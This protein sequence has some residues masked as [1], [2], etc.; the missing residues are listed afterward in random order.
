M[1]STII[2]EQHLDALARLGYF[3]MHANPKYVSGIMRDLRFAHPDL[4]LVENVGPDGIGQIVMLPAVREQI[5]IR[6]TEELEKYQAAAINTSRAIS[7]LT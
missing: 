7:A 2:L 1:S 5:R 3:E 4:I 6:L